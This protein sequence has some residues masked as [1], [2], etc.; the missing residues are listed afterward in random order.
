MT[1]KANV[2]YQVLIEPQKFNLLP[3]KENADCP[4]LTLHSI[5]D[6]PFSITRFSA[7]N[8]ALMVD[9]DPSLQQ[10]EYTLT[11]IVMT[12]AVEKHQRGILVLT[13]DHPKCPE[14][15]LRIHGQV[16]IRTQTRES[17]PSTISHPARPK[18]DRSFSPT[19]T[20]KTSPSNRPPRTSRWPKL[21]GQE[22]ISTGE[23]QKSLLLKIRITPQLNKPEDRQFRDYLHLKIKDG[24]HPGSGLLGTAIEGSW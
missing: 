14:V 19:T 7:T 8:N 23:Q 12:D 2:S 13:L 5:D 17:P 16:G 15:V 18:F 22:E 10:T 21:I 1:I 11:P 24:P 6:V 9:F 20:A 4:A 3:Q